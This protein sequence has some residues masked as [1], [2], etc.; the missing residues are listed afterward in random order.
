MRQDFER[1]YRQLKYWGLVTN[2]FDF[3]TR[4]LGQCRS[5]YSSMKARDAEPG[6]EAMVSLLIRLQRHNTSLKSTDTPRTCAAMGQLSSMLEL[7][8]SHL[9]EQLFEAG[10]RRVV[11][12][13]S[14]QWE[15][16]A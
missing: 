11:K 14:Q 15:M 13:Q 3:S 5:Y 7:E 2:Q 9:T 4:W 1:I 10:Y 8:A 6:T 16:A 12:R